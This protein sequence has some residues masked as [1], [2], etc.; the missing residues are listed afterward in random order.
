MMERITRSIRYDFLVLLLLAEFCPWLAAAHADVSRLPVLRNVGTIPVQFENATELAA[1]VQEGIA[2][3]FPDA[4]LA[5][6]RFRLLDPDLVQDLWASPKGRSELRDEYELQVYLLL[7][8]QVTGDI[9]SLEARLMDAYFKTLLQEGDRLPLQMVQTLDIETLKKNVELL[10]FRLLNRLPNDVHV[11][12]LQGP[13]VTLSGGQDQGI[14]AGDRVDILRSSITA[15]HPANGSWIEFRSAKMGSIKIMDAKESTA[16][17]RII[18]QTHA[19]AIQVGDGAKI[20]TI[21]S[22]VRFARRAPEETFPES[23]NQSAIILPPVPRDARYAE[24]Y[25]GANQAPLLRP[26]A[27][28][29]KS[30]HPDARGSQ[31]EAA[32]SP[33]PGPASPI[34]R[35]ARAIRADDDAGPSAWQNFAQEAL[36]QKTL[37]DWSVFVGPTW[38]S[39]RGPVHSS[40]SFPSWLLN[41]VGGSVT[42]TMFYKI[43]GQFGGG[44]LFGKTPAGTYL[45]YD[46]FAR[47]YWESELPFGYLNLWQAGV[48]GS[49]SGITASGGSFGGGDFIR[50]GFFGGLGGQFL[51][52]EA[53]EPYEW[54]MHY[55]LFP[56]NFGRVGYRGSFNE[57]ESAL[58]WKLDFSVYDRP[59][60]RAIQWG[61]GFAGGDERQTL[62]NGRRFHLNDQS[63]KL[64]AKL[65]L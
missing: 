58:G 15:T 41:S 52:G 10:T 11:T 3:A 37:E 12:S 63:L 13:Y 49:F 31:T 23:S 6:K 7:S 38:W 59:S 30:A 24:A 50:S 57:V 29:E 40:G 18:R 20:A 60:S 43:K 33:A 62:K 32:P 64:L 28:P 56:L 17:G 45:G 36:N 55:F 8:V 54:E 5:A 65:R 9:V 34:D 42:R 16:I 39:I 1:D 35:N 46:S 25:Q 27:Q 26:Q 14:E 61:I 22:R 44:G 47:L 4:V 19:R 48:S 21:P 2:A 53:A 51:V